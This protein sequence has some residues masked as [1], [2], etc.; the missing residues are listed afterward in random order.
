M[1]I[2]TEL[3][4]SMMN[5]RENN[6]IYKQ[7]QLPFKYFLGYLKGPSVFESQWDTVIY[8][9]CFTCYTFNSIQS[10]QIKW[11]TIIK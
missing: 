9:T 4:P 5:H 2:L 3:G 6:V 11:I 1:V 10:V 8:G 7:N